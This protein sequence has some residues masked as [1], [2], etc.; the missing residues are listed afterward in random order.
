[1]IVHILDLQIGK[2]NVKKYKNRIIHNF[3][4]IRSFQSNV[5]LL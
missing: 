2:I 4:F 5:A 3:V 1:M